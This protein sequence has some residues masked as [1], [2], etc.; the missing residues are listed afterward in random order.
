M[1]RGGVR[2]GSA[3]CW[4]WLAECAESLSIR[5]ELLSNWSRARSR[6]S[7]SVTLDPVAD[8]PVGAVAGE[9][10]KGTATR[11]GRKK[12]K[13]A[14]PGTSAAASPSKRRSKSGS[15]S[16]SRSDSNFKTNIVIS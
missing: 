11:G 7:A 14:R 8:G 2:S 6:S 4:W 10:R 3:R 5:L 13:A 15:G 12:E 1:I 16:S 9:G